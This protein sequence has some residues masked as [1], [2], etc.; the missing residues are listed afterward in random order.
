MVPIPHLVPHD[1]RREPPW[2]THRMFHIGLPKMIQQL[3]MVFAGFYCWATGMLG[4][5]KLLQFAGGTCNSVKLAELVEAQLLIRFNI[6]VRCIIQLIWFFVLPQLR[7]R[8]AEGKILPSQKRFIRFAQTE[9]QLCVYYVTMCIS[10]S[11]IPGLWQHNGNI[12]WGW[13]KTDYHI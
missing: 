2:S 10:C 5:G 3:A 9:Q 8:R 12:I 7:G 1:F 11:E 13:V 6:L 4:V